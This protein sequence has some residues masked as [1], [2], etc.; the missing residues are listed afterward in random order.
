MGD[1]QPRMSASERRI[2]ALENECRLLIAENEAQGRVI[3][4]LVGR[5]GGEAEVTDE[6][7]R[8][9]EDRALGIEHQPDRQLVRFTVHGHEVFEE[10]GGEDG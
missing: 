8:G 5:L 4:I 9:V 1:Y 3:T 10:G 6:E 2:A 7:I